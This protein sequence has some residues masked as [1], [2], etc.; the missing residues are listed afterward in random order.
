MIVRLLIGS[1]QVVA[2]VECSDFVEI[3]RAC[4]QCGRDFTT[5]IID[6]KYCSDKCRWNASADFKAMNSSPLRK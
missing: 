3:E 1:P 2:V 6:K 4:V 5:R